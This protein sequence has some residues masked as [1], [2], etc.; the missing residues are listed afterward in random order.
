M[1]Q[2]E[3]QIAKDDL[4]KQAA[5]ALST[6]QRHKDAVKI[7]FD[8]VEQGKIPPFETFASF[9]EKIAALMEKDLRVVEEALAM[10][11]TM[12]EFGKLAS[13]GPA[14]TDDAEANFYHA[15]ADDD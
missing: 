4:L 3:P 14:T 13:S 9:E 5:D 7:A 11:T 1:T 12:Q 6:A 8:M 15:L 2:L 10:D